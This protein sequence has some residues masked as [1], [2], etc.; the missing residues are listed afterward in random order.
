MNNADGGVRVQTPAQIID[1]ERAQIGHDL[2]DRLLPLIFA[3][4]AKLQSVSAASDD[5]AQRI[6]Q[7]QQWLQEA[8]V[9]GRNLLTEIYPPELDQLTWLAAAKDTVA[10]ICGDQAETVWTVAATSPV[11]DP[12]WERDVATSAYRVLI[13]AVRNALRHGKSDSISIRCQEDAI[14]IVDDGEG[15]DPLQVPTSRFGIRSMKGR[16]ALVGKR[17]SVDSQPG[18]PTTVRFDL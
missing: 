3:A 5:D 1:A 4:S 6:T 18:G 9:L 7:A 11:C 17:V 10:R 13:E 15:F 16:A 14:L 8:L 2:H 12:H